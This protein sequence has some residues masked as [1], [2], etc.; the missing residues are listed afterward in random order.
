MKLE[1]YLN[2]V[3]EKCE[4]QNKKGFKDSVYDNIDYELWDYKGNDAGKQAAT[5]YYRDNKWMDIYTDY[6]GYDVA[7]YTVHPIKL[8]VDCD[9][10]ETFASK[11]VLLAYL[12][13]S[14]YFTYKSFGLKDIQ[15]NT[16]YA[17]D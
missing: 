2:K 8:E 13:D 6:N 16:N 9:S 5:I 15:V 4:E 11:I 1:N 3:L 17:T 14:F 12:I 7:V 10:R